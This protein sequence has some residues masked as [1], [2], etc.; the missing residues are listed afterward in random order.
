MKCQQ[1]V[2][3][4]KSKVHFSA[5]FCVRKKDELDSDLTW[6]QT[7][8]ACPS[9]LANSAKRNDSRL[10]PRHVNSCP[11]YIRQSFNFQTA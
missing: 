11:Y 1:K 8:L 2:M 3:I 7:A 4:L 9:Y 5:K 10:N 6:I